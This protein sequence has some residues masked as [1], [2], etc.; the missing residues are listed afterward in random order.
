MQIMSTKKLNGTTT[1]TVKLWWRKLIVITLSK[2]KTFVIYYHN[3]SVIMRN[4][5]IVVLFIVLILFLILIMNNDGGWFKNSLCVKQYNK[6]LT[7]TYK[8]QNHGIINS[9]DVKRKNLIIYGNWKPGK[10]HNQTCDFIPENTCCKNRQNLHFEF[11]EDRLNKVD[12]VKE[13]RKILKTKKLL[14]IG[15]SLMSE[16]FVGLSELLLSK[17]EKKSKYFCGT[18]CTIHPGNNGTVTFLKACLIE[19]KRQ[20]EKF[21]ADEWRIVSEEVIRREIPKYDIILFNQ[22][23]HHESRFLVSKMPTY[24]TNIG[25]MLYGENEKKIQPSIRVFLK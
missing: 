22:G 11:Y 12:D 2:L 18:N 10:R 21:D 8:V 19:L 16:F 23:Q 15:D 4:L 17:T 24:F 13:L 5:N 3:G 9:K 7:E 14:L 25:K 6:N 1:P 20:G